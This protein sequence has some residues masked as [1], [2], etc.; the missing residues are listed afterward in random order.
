MSILN[1]LKR[2]GHNVSDICDIGLD[3]VKLGMYTSF[4]EAELKVRNDHMVRQTEIVVDLVE[5]L[6]SLRR[7]IN[8]L[9][10]EDINNTVD[11]LETALDS[12][13]NVKADAGISIFNVL[14]KKPENATK[15]ADSFEPAKLQKEEITGEEINRN[16]V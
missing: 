10:A 6:A 1:T 2:H 16:G 11:I 3:R 8:N 7:R 12:Y 4:K 9:A 5:D 13:G 15:A 14:R